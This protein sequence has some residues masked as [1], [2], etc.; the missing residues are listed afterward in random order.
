M[1][2]SLDYKEGAC[3][4]EKAGAGVGPALLLRIV[5]QRC[6]RKSENSGV[7]AKEVHRNETGN[8]RTPLWW[9]HAEGCQP[10][11]AHNWPLTAELPTMKQMASA[12]S[13]GRIRRRSS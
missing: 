13:S 4:A 8:H 9:R 1:G 11:S 10:A 3:V 12:I 5:R 2:F 7:S 6:G